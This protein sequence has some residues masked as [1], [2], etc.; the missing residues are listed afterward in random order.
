MVCVRCIIYRRLN[1]L[2]FFK[3]LIKLIDFLCYICSLSFCVYYNY[4][5]SH[6]CMNWKVAVRISPMLVFMKNIFYK[7][8]VFTD[9]PFYND[10][11]C[12][13][14][15]MFVKDIQTHVRHIWYPSVFNS[16]NS[17][18]NS[19]ETS[20]LTVPNCPLNKQ[21]HYINCFWD[22]CLILNVLHFGFICNKNTVYE[23]IMK[24][25][26]TWVSNL[27]VIE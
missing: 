11:S 3:T 25:T 16:Q 4:M 27:T 1:F 20:I 14:F 18:A 6:K 19:F 23:N 2:V 17:I 5:Y 8:H 9:Q 10:C 15:Q 12:T 13:Y 7:A 24:K 21:I 22:I 26:D